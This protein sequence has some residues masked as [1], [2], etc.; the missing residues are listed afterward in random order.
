[1]SVTFCHIAAPGAHPP[2]SLLPTPTFSYPTHCTAHCS[3][4]LS[5]RRSGALVT[6]DQRCLGRSPGPPGLA[7][8]TSYFLLALSIFPLYLAPAAGSDAAFASQLA[9]CTM[10]PASCSFRYCLLLLP[11]RALCLEC[12][13]AEHRPAVPAALRPS[14]ASKPPNQS[15]LVRHTLLVTTR[16]RLTL[17]T[18]PPLASTGSLQ[19]AVV[20]PWPCQ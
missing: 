10:L 8:P 1:M 4:P 7:L 13:R 11:S 18:T 14:T 6:L 12:L 17:R 20:H 3:A 16:N 2:V 9:P 5:S 19:L 15:S